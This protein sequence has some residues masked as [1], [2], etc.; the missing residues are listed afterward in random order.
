M[1]YQ[2]QCVTAKAPFAPRD[3]A[4][5]LVYEDKMYLIGGWNPKDKKNFPLVCNNEVWSSVDGKKWLLEKANTFAHEGKTFN[6]FSDWEGRHCAGYVTFKNKM[7]IVGG[8]SNQGHYHSDVWN[9]DDGRVWHQINRNK[10]V[11]WVPRVGFL[12]TVFRDK[13]W[14]LGGQTIPQFA[15]ADELFYNDI[16]NS[17][18]GLHW[19]KVVTDGTVWGARAFAGK[20]L[21]FKDRLW[22][23]GGGTYTTEHHE[24]R[25]YND[26]WSSLDGR[27]WECCLSHAPWEPK[28]MHDVAV[29]DNKLWMLE[30]YHTTAR[31]QNDVW[32]SEDGKN[33]TELP[34]TPWKPRH[35]ASVFVYQ[36][37]L[38]M[39]AGNNM[40]SD[41]WKLTRI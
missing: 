10:P 14:I 4:G 5:A 41:V 19:D 7:W 2:W 22:I 17:S 28:L 24:K 38:W 21:V 18:D 16:W 3:G 20:A 30:G 9:S 11:P 25:V 35:A 15:P 31:N 26:V 40:T 39:V 27:R 36:D 33:W 32:Y 6:R 29:F 8:D 37:A 34:G 23:F 12:T 1:N 13:I